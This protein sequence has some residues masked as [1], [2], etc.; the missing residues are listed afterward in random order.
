MIP[1]FG[2]PERKSEWKALIEVLL[3]MVNMQRKSAV[4][5]EVVEAVV[6]QCSTDCL[7]ST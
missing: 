3:Q 2:V 1:A 6:L 4:V 7:H 5:P